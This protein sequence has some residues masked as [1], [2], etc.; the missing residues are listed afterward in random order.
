MNAPAL[1]P[2]EAR[3]LFFVPVTTPHEQ[4]MDEASVRIRMAQGAKG[5]MRQTLLKAAD[6]W[7]FFAN[8]LY[9]K[10]GRR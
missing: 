8:E 3:G 7:T 9:A 6:A 4:A 10:G 5:E 1:T 2:A